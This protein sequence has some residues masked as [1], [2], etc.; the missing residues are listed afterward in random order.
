MVTTVDEAGR[1]NAASFGTCVRVCHDPVYISF[2]V[3]A[4]KDTAHNVLCTGEFVVNVPPFD[5]EIL[6]ENKEGRERM[7]AAIDA[8]RAEAI[9]FSR[10]ARSIEIFLS[11]LEGLGD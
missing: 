2:T 1:V 4:P 3:G 11:D 10:G 7:Q 5:R 8:L 9:S 6:P